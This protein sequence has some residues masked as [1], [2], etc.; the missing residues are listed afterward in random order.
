M[1]EGTIDQATGHKRP[2]PCGGVAQAIKELEASE[3]AGGPADVP[4]ENEPQRHQWIVK[5]P[6]VMG[7]EI[8][9]A[10]M[11]DVI[12]SGALVFDNVVKHGEDEV[13]AETVLAFNSRFWLEARRVT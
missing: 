5:R 11:M 8:V 6:D 7:K 12:P 3:S 4:A 2:M 1:A 10:D 13:I 9:S